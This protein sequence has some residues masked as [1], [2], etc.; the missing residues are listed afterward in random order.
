MEA[1]FFQGQGLKIGMSK[2]WVC[3]LQLAMG[4]RGGKHIR[5]WGGVA[6]ASER[7]EGT[8]AIRGENLLIRER[9]WTGDGMTKSDV[10]LRQKIVGERRG[11]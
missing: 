1:L 8:S 9:K 2:N 7:I 4:T 10:K 5:I 3:N 6:C 11:D